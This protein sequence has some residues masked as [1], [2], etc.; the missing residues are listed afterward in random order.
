MFAPAFGRF[1]PGRPV[2][3]PG[4]WRATR[5]GVLL[6]IAAALAS[7]PSVAGPQGVQLPPDPCQV[8]Q[9]LCDTGSALY[10]TLL[11][12]TG[13]QPGDGAFGPLHALLDEVPGGEDP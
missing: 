4:D 7:V 8:D 11:N 9:R 5:G 3:R 6:P 1:V 13:A 12:L 2:G 10:D